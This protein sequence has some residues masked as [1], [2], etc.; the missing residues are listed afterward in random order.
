ME[1]VKVTPQE[2]VQLQ[3]ISKKTFSDAFAKDNNP[4]DLEM[5][6][7]SAYSVDKLNTEL[8]NP[9]SEF[10]FINVE[11]T[12]VGYLKINTGMAQTENK[13]SDSL[14]V[15]RIYV[16]QKLH[17]AGV[18]KALLDKA[19]ELARE[20]NLKYVWLGVWEK[21]PRAIRFY[22]KNGFT[23]FGSHKFLIGKDEQTDILLRL[24]LE[25]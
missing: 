13:G 24:Y 15:E 19:F 23:V 3:H 6:L 7:N 5:F 12:P 22:Q 2:V 1:I 8:L 11:N 14:E 18:G 4:D 17:G 10:Y 16:E 21:N 25:N 9:E 20:R